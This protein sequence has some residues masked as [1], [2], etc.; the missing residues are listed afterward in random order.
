MCPERARICVI[1]NEPLYIQALTIVF[2]TSDDHQVVASAQT[3]E[4]A[5]LLVDKF[6][7]LDI[8]VVIL[9]TKLKSGDDEGVKSKKILKKIREVAPNVK[10]ISMSSGTPLKGSDVQM[11]KHYSREEIIDVVTNL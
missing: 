1:D 11:Y 5:V 8:N 4:D 3:I 7:E 10:V 6:K 2:E 9:D